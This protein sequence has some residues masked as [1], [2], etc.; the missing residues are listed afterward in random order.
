MDS[1]DSLKNSLEIAEYELKWFKDYKDPIISEII[2][3]NNKHSTHDA[4]NYRLPTNIIPNAYV[5]NVTPHINESDNFT[6]DGEVNISAA[7]ANKTNSIVL[8]SAEITIHNVVISVGNDT[9]EIVK[10][11]LTEEYNFFT[12]ELAQELQVGA[13]VIIKIK[14]TGYLNEEMRGFYRSSYV[15]VNGKTRCVKK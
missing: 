1:L 7:V 11:N 5:I 3:F 4:K 15:D 9:F 14:Y 2:D 12:I 6:F 10:K 8:H 13:T